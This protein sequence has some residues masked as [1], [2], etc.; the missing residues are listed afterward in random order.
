MRKHG[1]HP[2]YQINAGSPFQC[3]SVQG[4]ILLDIVGDICNMHSQMVVSFLIHRK[5]DCIIQILGIL[6][7][8]GNHLYLS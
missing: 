3:L 4:R 5:A 6:T 1:N 7:I 8:D 2:V